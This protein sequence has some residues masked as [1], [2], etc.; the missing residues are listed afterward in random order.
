MPIEETLLKSHAVGLIGQVFLNKV[1]SQ[2]SH[3]SWVPSEQPRAKSKPWVKQEL[4]ALDDM[5]T[6]IHTLALAITSVPDLSNRALPPF[7]SPVRLDWCRIGV[8]LGAIFAFYNI[9]PAA[10]KQYYEAWISLGD[11][12][13][14]RFLSPHRCAYARCFNDSLI[15]Y[16][17]LKA[18]GFCPTTYYCSHACQ[19]G[20]VPID[21]HIF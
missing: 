19:H 11:A 10:Y 16:G 13:D 18:C 6:A 17:T 21:E 5:I 7:T 3:M 1:T 15:P 8:Q 20:Y 9:K 4:D 14:F 2:F 12:F